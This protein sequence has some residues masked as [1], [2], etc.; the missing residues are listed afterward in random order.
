VESSISNVVQKIAKG[1]RDIPQQ[2]R[3]DFCSIM[4]K[5]GFDD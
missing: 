5:Y 3:G 1:Y 2:R 4:R